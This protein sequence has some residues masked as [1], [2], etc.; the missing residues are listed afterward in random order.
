ML[1]SL[2]RHKSQGL[3]TGCNGVGLHK[4]IGFFSDNKIH[5]QRR[6]HVHQFQFPHFF[7]E[8]LFSSLFTLLPHFLPHLLSGWSIFFFTNV[9]RPVFLSLC[10]I[11]NC[12]FPRNLSSLLI[13]ACISTILKELLI[14]SVLTSIAHTRRWDC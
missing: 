2:M 6:E 11:L 5:G 10:P 9:T 13:L 8:K 12:F 3:S 4:R 1:T 14:V 7:K